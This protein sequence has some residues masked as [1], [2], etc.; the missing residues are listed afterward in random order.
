M[1]SWRK[2][3][4][5]GKISIINMLL[6]SQLIHRLSVLRIPQS[7][8]I[9]SI[10]MTFH[11]YL[12]NDKPHM[13]PK[14]VVTLTYDQGGIKMVDIYKKDQSLKITWIK[15]IWEEPEYHICPTLDKVNKIPTKLLFKCN[16][17]SK[18]IAHCWK[19]L[20]VP[21]WVDMMQHWCEYNYTNIKDCSDDVLNEIIWFNSNIRVQNKPV[22]HKICMIE[23]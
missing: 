5:Y 12:W 3:T 8:I 17:H 22:F 16:L 9:K 18:D 15:R 4:L 13:I 2:L 6:S 7:D 19:K 1:W 14:T 11:N 21:F 10:D 20:P 23:T